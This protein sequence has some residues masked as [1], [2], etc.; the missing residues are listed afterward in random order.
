MN[1]NIENQINSIGLKMDLDK[2][3]TKMDF[4]LAIIKLQLLES[5]EKGELTNEY[6]QKKFLE[7]HILLDELSSLEQ[8]AYLYGDKDLVNRCYSIKLDIIFFAESIKTFI[9]FD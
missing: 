3:E 7:L 2:F 1:K 5:E 6:V 8:K 9:K 4:S